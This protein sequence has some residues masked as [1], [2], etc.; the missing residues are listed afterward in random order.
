MRHGSLIIEFLYSFYGL[1]L[2]IPFFELYDKL[3]V[4][5]YQ[6][7]HQFY[8]LSYR[9]LDNLRVDSDFAIP[10]LSFYDSTR[11]LT[12]YHDRTEVEYPRTNSARSA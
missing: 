6:N 7:V 3:T 4:E 1:V 8:E 10:E 9:S 11:R 5:R 12:C 2:G